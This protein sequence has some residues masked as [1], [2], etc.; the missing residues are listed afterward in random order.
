MSADLARQEREVVD[1]TIHLLAGVLDDRSGAELVRRMLPAALP[2]VRFLPDTAIDELAAELVATAYVALSLDN[3]APVSQLLIEWRHTAEV[4]ADP[5]LHAMLTRPTGD[6]FGP[7]PA[8]GP[9][10]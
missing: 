8:P 1:L 5:K 10:A 9:A 6:D 2:W 7:V 3:L 4:H